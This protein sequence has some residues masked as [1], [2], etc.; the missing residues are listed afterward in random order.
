MKLE[1][2]KYFFPK[3]EI[4]RWQN[5][6][7]LSEELKNHELV[8]VKL[9]EQKERIVLSKEGSVDLDYLTSLYLSFKDDIK[10][11]KKEELLSNYKTTIKLNFYKDL[12]ENVMVQF[13][14]MYLTLD[15]FLYVLNQKKDK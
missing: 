7:Q 4:E 6:E 13:T 11:L 5:G 3:E 8:F 12:N 15:N 10:N 14:C 9:D 1:E 2:L